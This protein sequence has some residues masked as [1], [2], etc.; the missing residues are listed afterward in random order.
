MNTPARSPFTDAAESRG[1]TYDEG[2]ALTENDG[3]A[4]SGN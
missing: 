4:S 3:E 1:E 2:R